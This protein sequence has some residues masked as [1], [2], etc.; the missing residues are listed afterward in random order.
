MVNKPI[1]SLGLT[2]VELVATVCIAGVLAAV[3]IPNFMNVI[4]NNRTTSVANQLVAALAYT[5]SEAIKRGLQVT[6]KHKDI[7]A[8]VWDN[9]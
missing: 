5:R 9:G 6:M 3:A 7:T 8:R 4:T 2:L 1:T